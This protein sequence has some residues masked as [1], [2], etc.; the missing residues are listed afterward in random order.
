MTLSVA[1]ETAPAVAPV[2]SQWREIWHRFCRHRLALISFYVL[3]FLYAVCFLGEALVSASPYEQKTD[4]GYTPP[5]AIHLWDNGQLAAPYTYGITKS[6]N[7]T[8]FQWEYVQD[9]TKKVPLGFFVPGSSYRLL[10]LIETDRHLFGATDGQ[11]V[12]FLGSDQF[13]RDLLSRI[14]VGGR[15]SL[16]IPV[17]AVLITVVLGTLIGAVS[18][19]VGGWAD[20][21]I[22]RFIEVLSGF[23]RLALWMALAAVI[24]LGSQ[25]AA[26]YAAMAAILAVIGWGQL[27]RQIRGRVLQLR[28]A[29]YVLAAQALGGSSWRIITRHLVPNLISVIVVVASVSIPEYLLVE[30]SLSFL[31]IGLTPPLVSWG[32]LLKDAQTVRVVVQYPWLLAPGFFIIITMLAFNFVGDGIR[33]AFET[34]RL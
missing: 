10:G 31:G 33:D 34:R 13:G 8:T 18:G 22:Q 9:T 29:E 1:G 6:L 23:P 24:P 32:V 17:A 2:E 27:A 3:I 5:Q 28:S 25:G 21:L 20:T 7:N 19:Y 30:S 14:L 4:L 12:Y 15:L 26:T 16:T 11:T